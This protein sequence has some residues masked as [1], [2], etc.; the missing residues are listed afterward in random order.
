MKTVPVAVM[1]LVWA[2]ET[3]SDTSC[4]PSSCPAVGSLSSCTALLVYLVSSGTSGAGVPVEVRSPGCL[5][6]LG[7]L[8]FLL[9]IA[10]ASGL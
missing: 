6:N 2:A 1:N 7:F 8:L 10:G 5:I 9:R 3:T 4:V